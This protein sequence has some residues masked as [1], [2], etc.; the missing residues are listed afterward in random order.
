M[1]KYFVAFNWVTKNNIRGFSNCIKTS[2][3]NLSSAK[4]INKWEEEIKMSKE[5]IT[6]INII[7]FKEVK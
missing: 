3:N 7:F 1:K 6:F 5:N 4:E 2:L